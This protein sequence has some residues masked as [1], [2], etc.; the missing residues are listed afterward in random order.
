ME[1][2]E[3]EGWAVI[4][5]TG[6]KW[7]NREG[8]KRRAGVKGAIALWQ[9]YCSV[10][11]NTYVNK[12]CPEM[13]CRGNSLCDVSFCWEPHQPS[14]PPL[15]PP[16]HSFLQMLTLLGTAGLCL[17]APQAQGCSPPS[18][19]AAGGKLPALHSYSCYPTSLRSVWASSQ[20]PKV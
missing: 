8:T 7:A 3:G 11:G 19:A 6:L 12:E 9:T 2:R 4:K 5:G 1:G 20:L 10:N 16:D 13:G 15:P 14:P 17:W 18:T